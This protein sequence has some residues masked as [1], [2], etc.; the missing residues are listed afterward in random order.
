MTF[1]DEVYELRR[2]GLIP[3]V[4]KVHDLRPY[5][6][7]PDGQYAKIAVDTIP[8]NASISFRNDEIGNYV[9]NRKSDPRAWRVGP[10]KSGEY[11]LVVDPE[12]DLDTQEK[13]RLLAL[14][15]AMELRTGWSNPFRGKPVKYA[16]PCDLPVPDNEWDAL[17]LEKW[18]ARLNDRP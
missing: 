9:K 15:R 5:L 17:F 12:D 7:R 13:E 1:W 6:Q 16:G 11:K 2:K 8:A 3:R 4:W 10:P 14:L 18:D